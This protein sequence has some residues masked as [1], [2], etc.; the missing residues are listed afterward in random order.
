MVNW[1]VG[2]TK[3]QAKPTCMEVDNSSLFSLV[4]TFTLGKIATIHQVTTVLATYFQVITTG[5]D[6]PTLWLSP[7]LTLVQ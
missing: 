1:F 7:S 4:F 2:N 5:A 3:S 6:E